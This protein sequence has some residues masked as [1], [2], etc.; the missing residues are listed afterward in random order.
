M[1]EA[2]QY[3]NEQLLKIVAYG[4]CV[5]V[6][7]WLFFSNYSLLLLTVDWGGRENLI[8]ILLNILMFVIF[9]RPL[10][11]LYKRVSVS[12]ELEF[13]EMI[14][15]FIW[16]IGPLFAIGLFFSALVYGGI[17]A[18]YVPGILIAPILFI[19]PFMYSGTRS[20]RAWIKSSIDFYINHFVQVWIQIIFWSSIVTLV[21][22]GV[23]YITS[24]LEM[25]YDA[26]N[27]TR[28]VFSLVIFPFIVFSLSEKFLSM[29]EEVEDEWTN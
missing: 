23:L 24:F 25:S 16:S 28:L 8:N 7:A 1:R 26:Y 2:A 19:L 6:P 29:T 3:Y 12:D 11:S 15:E 18:F 27:I 22:A 17:F 13:K 14:K 21:W 20:I 4:L 5:M 10:F 9:V